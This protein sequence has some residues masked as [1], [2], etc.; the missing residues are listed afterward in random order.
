MLFLILTFAFGQTY[1]SYDEASLAARGSGKMLVVEFDDNDGCIN[2]SLPRP[3]LKECIRCKLNTSSP[4]LQKPGFSQLGGRGIAFVKDNEV[5]SI[6]PAAY[7]NPGY[8][9]AMLELPEGTLT[10]RMLVWAIRIHPER[11]RSTNGTAD[12]NLMQHCA[13][14]SARQAAANNQHHD[15][16]YAAFVTHEVVAETW[17]WH[18]DVASAAIDIIDAWRHSPSHWSAVSGSFRSYGYDMVYSPRGG[19]WFATGV[20]NN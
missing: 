14:H 7:F 5:V 4:L 11:P 17:P 16:Q 12:P 6:L 8:L 15:M 13:S 10:Q 2:E 18:K 9:D 1:T 19:K 3:K 20:V